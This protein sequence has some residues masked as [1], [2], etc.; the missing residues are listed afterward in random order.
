MKLIIN[1][2]NQNKTINCFALSTIFVLTIVFNITL[3]ARMGYDKIYQDVG[4]S[5]IL[6]VYEGNV[7][8][9]YT[10]LVPERF[11]PL[12][13]KVPHVLDVA[14]E[15]RQRYSFEKHTNL[16][17]SAMKPDKLLKFKDLNKGLDVKQKE[18]KAFKNNPRGALVGKKIFRMYGWKKGETVK[19]YGLEFKIDGVFE[20]PLSVYES[21]IFLHKSYL[22]Q[23]TSKTGFATTFLVKTDLTD[24]D[25][26]HSLMKRI[27]KLCKDNPSR[28]SCRPEDE[29]WQAIQ[30]SQGNLGGIITGLA[31]SLG[32]LIIVLHINNAFFILRY[33]WRSIKKLKA[34]GFSK[35]NVISIIFSETALL[36]SVAGISASV[37]IYL[38]L[39]KFTIYVGKDLFHPPIFINLTVLLAGISLSLAAAMIAS[40][41]IIPVT[42]NIYD[43]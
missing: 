28:I 10:S 17:L 38:S 19:A 6:A 5:D 18:F 40:A 1:L 9:P 35:K 42:M 11:G 23:L 26:L 8:C 37:I 2:I 30:S 7:A 24:P 4:K 13:S 20:K 14:A 25:E 39:F 16:T 27:E 29:L 15:I 34:D 3:G 31:L 43:K 36:L 21:M 12:I 22:Q 41:S 32:I 33:K